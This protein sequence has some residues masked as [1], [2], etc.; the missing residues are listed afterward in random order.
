MWWLL[1]TNNICNMPVY[2]CNFWQRQTFFFLTLFSYVASSSLEVV[3]FL[4]Y[5]FCLVGWVNLLFAYFLYSKDVFHWAGSVDTILLQAWQPEL[6]PRTHYSN[7]RTSLWK[8]FFYI[9]VCALTDSIKFG[10]NDGS[11]HDMTLQWSGGHEYL[12]LWF[13]FVN[14]K[15]AVGS[16][17]PKASDRLRAWHALNE[18]VYQPLRSHC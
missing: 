5:L 15:P 7:E 9:Y 3:T 12:S 1:C 17:Y 11:I 4:V 6:E 16:S 8:L 18:A 13:S 2:I 14:Y 10:D